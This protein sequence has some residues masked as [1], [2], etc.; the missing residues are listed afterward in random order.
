MTAMASQITDVSIVYSTVF[1]L[2]KTSKL[3]VTGICEGNSTVTGNH[4]DE[5]DRS[6]RLDITHNDM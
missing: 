6:V 3:R 1:F 2:K 4:D 5:V